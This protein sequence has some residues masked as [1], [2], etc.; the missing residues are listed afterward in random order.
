MTGAVVPVRRG[1]T[2]KPAQQ[3]GNVVPLRPA[4]ESTEDIVRGVQERS[5]RQEADISQQL[6]DLVV[7]VHQRHRE[8]AQEAS[9][10][11]V[12]M[13]GTQLSDWLEIGRRM[14]AA[15]GGRRR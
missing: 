11:G 6:R 15:Q 5:R 2:R 1:R 10:I 8:R 7:T 3:V 14:L 12:A 9:R 13:D 4:P